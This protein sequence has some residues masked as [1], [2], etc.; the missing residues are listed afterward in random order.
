MNLLQDILCN[1]KEFR[2]VSFFFE[3]GSN[4]FVIK[5]KMLI[6]ENY[7]VLDV[8]VKTKMFKIILHI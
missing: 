5:Y 3:R 4:L 2:I 1:R 8:S 6:Y 7:D